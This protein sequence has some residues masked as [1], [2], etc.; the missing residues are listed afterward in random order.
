MGVIGAADVVFGRIVHVPAPE[1]ETA[2]AVDDYQHSKPEVLILGSSYVRSFAPLARALRELPRPLQTSV[3]PIE[4]GRFLA[5]E[6]VLRQR[7]LPLIDEQDSSGVAVRPPLK[8]MVLVT[9]YWDMC[10]GDDYPN[11]PA[12]AWGFSDYLRDLA[13]NGAT[14]FN[15]NYPDQ[16]WNELTRFSTLSRDRGVGRI[17]R[18]LRERINPKGEQER[19]AS[20]ARSL[21]GWIGMVVAGDMA[22]PECQMQQQD[23]ALTAIMEFT[24]ERNIQLT[25]VLWPLVPKAVTPESLVVTDRF[26]A[27]L[28]ER[29]GRYGARVLDFQENSPLTNDDFRKD[30]DHLEPW[31]DK[32][33][34]QW[35]LRGPLRF[36]DGGQPQAFG[37]TVEQGGSP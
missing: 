29:A 33:I 9:S 36:L 7:L 25:F 32:K 1:Y 22:R 3:V 10:G 11:I 21:D 26:K 6:W 17:L 31:G 20:E 13:A 5:Y 14:S 2:D 15:A 28:I 8:H 16:R 27:H 23:E 12:R 37:P 30:L 18:G 19:Q 35:A 4:G 34:S 24:K